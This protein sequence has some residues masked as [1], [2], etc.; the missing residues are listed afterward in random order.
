MKPTFRPSKIRR[1]RKFGYRARKA[2]HAGRKVL[3]ARRAKGRHRLA[4]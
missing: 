3:A 2:T 4:A 1:A